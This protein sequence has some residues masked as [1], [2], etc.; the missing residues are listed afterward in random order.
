MVQKSKNIGILGRNFPKNSNYNA[1]Q[2]G[3]V[4]L[5]T[6]HIVKIISRLIQVFSSSFLAMFGPHI[7]S[8]IL[9]MRICHYI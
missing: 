2:G 4:K 5:I 1:W 8:S 6:K 7:P 9:S 3:V